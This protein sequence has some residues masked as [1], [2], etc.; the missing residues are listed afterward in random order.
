ME[1]SGRPTQI[2]LPSYVSAEFLETFVMFEVSPTVEIGSSTY[3][4]HA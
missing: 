4:F 1:Q 2:C 3:E